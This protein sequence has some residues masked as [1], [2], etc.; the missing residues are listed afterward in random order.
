MDK[1]K[2]AHEMALAMAAD[3]NVPNENIV[4]IVW[5]YA[6]A[7]QAEADTREDK[8]RPDALKAVQQTFINGV[9]QP[10]SAPSKEEWQPDWSQAPDGYNWFCV[11]L[12]GG[13]GFFTNQAPELFEDYYIVGAD[14]FVVRNH[15]YQGDW[16]ESLRERPQ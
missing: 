1:M 10:R 9:E 16:R 11:G 14:G 4:T 13:Y 7:M 8:A 12:D 6:D 15:S 3:G 2:L 5:Q